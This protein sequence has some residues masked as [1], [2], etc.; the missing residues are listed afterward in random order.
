[1]HFEGTGQV[2]SPTGIEGCISLEEVEFIGLHVDSLR[3]FSGLSDLRRL[4]VIGGPAIADRVL[5]DLE[6]VAGRENWRH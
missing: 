3:P 6:D 4:L 5:L 2:F 1:V